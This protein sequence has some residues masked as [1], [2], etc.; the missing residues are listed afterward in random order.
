MSKHKMRVQRRVYVSGRVQG[1]GYRASTFREALRHSTVN[2]YVR[3]L[4]DGRVEA[5]FSGD[6]S[7]VEAMVNWCRR[8][9]QMAQVTELKVIEET[10]DP[11]LTSFQFRD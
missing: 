2:G 9:P 5:V 4:P 3:N 8:G 7:Q 6:A 1:V 11:T 10:M